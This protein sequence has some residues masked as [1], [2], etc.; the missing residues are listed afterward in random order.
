MCIGQSEVFKMPMGVTNGKSKGK[1]VAHGQ[2]TEMPP[3]PSAKDVEKWKEGDTFSGVMMEYKKYTGPLKLTPKKE[4]RL[5]HS[6]YYFDDE[7]DS[8]SSDE[9]GQPGHKRK[10]SDASSDDDEFSDVVPI[11]RSSSEDIGRGE[12][13]VQ[14]VESDVQRVESDV[15]RG[16]SD[17]Q[18]GRVMYKGERVKK[19]LSKG[20][21]LLEKHPRYIKEESES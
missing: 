3:P 4:A 8:S 6:L 11:Q 5:L 10:R 17:V 7:E 21:R 12:S 2:T 14:R 20:V 9:S 13:D 1:T 15:Q 19:F 18:R 16:E